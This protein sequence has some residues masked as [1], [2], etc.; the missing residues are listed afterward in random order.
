MPSYKCVSI[1]PGHMLMITTHIAFLFTFFLLIIE[2]IGFKIPN[3]PLDKRHERLFSHWNEET[4][5]FTFQLT[6]DDGHESKFTKN[7]RKKIQDEATANE[8]RITNN[9]SSDIGVIGNATVSVN[10]LWQSY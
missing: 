8:A 2:V 6:F 9:V 5:V 10:D 7:K 1:H 4:Q 3:I